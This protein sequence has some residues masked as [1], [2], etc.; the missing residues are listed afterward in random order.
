MG[1]CDKFEDASGIA[2]FFSCSMYDMDDHGAVPT[3]NNGSKKVSL[4]KYLIVLLEIKTML[5]VSWSCKAV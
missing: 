4:L 1:N 2:S 3:R 5:C